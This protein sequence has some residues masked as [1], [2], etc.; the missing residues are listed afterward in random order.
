MASQK[1]KLASGKTEQIRPGADLD[2]IGA[3]LGG[4]DVAFDASAHRPK[5]RI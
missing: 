2:S 5:R 3:G 4:I 1:G